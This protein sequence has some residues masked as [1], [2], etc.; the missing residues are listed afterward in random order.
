[1]HVLKP[2]FDLDPKVPV[3][4]NVNKERKSLKLEIVPA[5]EDH[6]FGSQSN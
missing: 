3:Y 4:I 6:D 2:T 5:C 1:M